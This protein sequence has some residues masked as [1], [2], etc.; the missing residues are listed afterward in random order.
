MFL[1]A[2]P[3]PA[4][5]PILIQIGPLA[6]RWYSLAYI[7][8]LLLGWMYIKKLLSQED[9]WAQ[10]KAPMTILQSDDFLLWT[11]LGV[12]LG[13]R[14][15][16]TLFYNFS[17]YAEN[18]LAILQVWNGGMSFHGGLLG[19]TI[20]III[21]CRRNKLKFLSVIDLVAVAV[22]IGLFFGRL[23][24]FIN[25]ELYGRVTDVAWGVVFPGGGPLPRH[26]SQVYEALLEGLV[27]FFVLRFL[28]Q[29]YKI[30]QRPGMASGV[31][32]LGYGLSRIFVEFFRMPDAQLGYFFGFITMG[33]ILSVPM[34]LTGIGVVWYVKKA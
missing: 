5:D 1:T 25:G 11:A 32:L 34:V 20:A 2:I 3:F 27:M 7:A 19:V 4:I 30:L 17:Y 24:N 14:I 18:P 22:P 12:I 23:A 6:I 26:A 9:L 13:G 10:K 16:Y 15:G 21:Y 28:V 29:K 33:M 31:F 8:G